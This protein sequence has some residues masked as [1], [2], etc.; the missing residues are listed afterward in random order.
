MCLV[1]VVA[2]LWSLVLMVTGLGRVEVP[3]SGGGRTW[4]YDR[5]IEVQSEAIG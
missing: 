2:G 4:K 1:L 5:N 3:G